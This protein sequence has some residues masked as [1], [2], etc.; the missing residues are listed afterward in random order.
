MC[1]MINKTRYVFRSGMKCRDS[2]VTYRNESH[3]PRAVRRWRSQRPL[4]RC[5]GDCSAIGEAAGTIRHGIGRN[6]ESTR[7]TREIFLMGGRE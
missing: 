1:A 2:G 3:W 5:S 4:P 6:R 7:L